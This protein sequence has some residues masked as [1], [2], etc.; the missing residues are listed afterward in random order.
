VSVLRR[1][2]RLAAVTFGVAAAGVVVPAPPGQAATCSTA[3]GVTVVVDF[4]QLGQG[5]GT[6][7]DPSGGGKSAADLFTGAG[8]AL[9]YVNGEPF[10]CEVDGAPTTQCVRTPPANAYWSLW[11]S[12]GK[13]GTW[14]YASTGVTALHVPAG[15]YVALSW[16]KGTAQAP[17]GVGATSHSP[18]S[19]TSHP[20]KSPTQH[21]TSTPPSSHPTQGATSP[22]SSA[23]TGPITPT[24]TPSSG[25]PSS[26]SSSSGHGKHSRAPTPST[27]A[28]PHHHA[29]KSAQD[30]ADGPVA[31]VASGDGGD[32][33]S[34]GLPGWVAPTA[35]VV[36]FAA[37]GTI[38]LVRRKSSGGT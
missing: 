2:L 28:R 38:A 23:T 18:S 16:Q 10:V 36:L 25:S 8:Y 37:G 17:P 24:G 9:T 34:G 12:D 29:S 21:P 6:S 30:Q 32:G 26:G 3:S 19:P 5:L 20:T 4:H 33:G 22:T 7:C 27:T 35:I 1:A 15:G 11:W 31:G 14:K 13:S